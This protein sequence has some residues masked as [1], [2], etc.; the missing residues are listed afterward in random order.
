[1]IYSPAIGR[2]DDSVRLRVARTLGHAVDGAG[3]PRVDRI[4]IELPH[5]V[6]ALT[7]LLGRVTAIEVN[8]PP[9]Q[10]PP[11]LNLPGW[12]GKPQ[13]VMTASGVD[14]SAKLLIIPG[15]VTAIEVNWPPLQRP[16]NLNLP[17]WEGKP[18]HV[19]TASGVDASAKLLIIPYATRGAL[20]LMVLRLAANLPVDPADRETPA[21]LTAGSI[22]LA[23]QQQCTP[24][25]ADYPRRK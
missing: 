5:V 6:A 14:A 22:L 1:M 11:N 9:L 8:W 20:A 13:H 7:P 24:I 21:F 16:P 4:T 23:A 3:W 18:Q 12:E 19:M 10:R 2:R 25:K 15:R 17:G